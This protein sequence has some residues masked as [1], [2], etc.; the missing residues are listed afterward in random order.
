[1]MRKNVLALL[2][3]VTVSLIGGQ[4]FAQ[5]ELRADQAPNALAA[6]KHSLSF[7]LPGGGNPY[8]GGAFGYWMMLTPEINFGINVGLAVDRQGNTVNDDVITSW[9]LLLAPTMKFYTSRRSVVAP[10]Y[11]AQLNLRLNDSG[12]A[13]SEVNTEM[14]L[15]GGIGVEWF[16]VTN[17]SVGGHAG[18][19]LDIIRSGNGEPI[20]VGT[21][22]SGLSAQIYF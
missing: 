2:A 19:G 17:F 4:A 18:L 5:Q 14:G 7:A 9:D 16:P 22:T 21:F 6:G 13:N 10:Y 20:A 3:V 1:M 11:F 12:A 15:A 8:A